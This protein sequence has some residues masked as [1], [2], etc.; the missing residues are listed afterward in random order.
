MMRRPPRSGHAATNTPRHP[1]AGIFGAVGASAAAKEATGKDVAS[2][3]G[4]GASVAAL[5]YATGIHSAMRVG[6]AQ[7]FT[8]AM[9]GA[10]AKIGAVGGLALLAGFGIATAIK[11]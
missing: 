8:G 1:S 10:G 5:G 2:A 7:P 3:A 6:A 4:A 9:A 11:D